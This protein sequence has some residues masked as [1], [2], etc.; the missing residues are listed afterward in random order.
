VQG[1]GRPVALKRADYEQRF[2]SESS[3]KS[4][5]P[6]TAEMSLNLENWS[7]SNRIRKCN[8][9]Y[10]QFRN[11]FTLPNFTLKYH[12]F[13]LTMGRGSFPKDEAENPFL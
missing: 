10:S 5:T 1:F 8:F 9:D 7:H 4:F 13:A 2:L 6:D 11:Y 3:A 12:F